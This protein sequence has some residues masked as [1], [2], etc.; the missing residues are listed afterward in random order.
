MPDRKIIAA[1]MIAMIQLNPIIFTGKAQMSQESSINP[2][3]S[4]LP[5]KSGGAV[6]S[7]ADALQALNANSEELLSVLQNCQEDA[8]SAALRNPVFDNTHL[9]VLLKR[10]N[11]GSVI[12]LIYTRKRHLNTNPVK[13]AL[14]AHPETPPHIAQAILP[15]LPVFELLKLCLMPRVSVDIHVAAERIIAQQIPAQP[16]GN[17]LTLARRGTAAILDALLRDGVQSVM[18]IC[19]D[20]PRLKEGTLHQFLAS[21]HA[22]AENVTIVA[23]N[24]RWQHRPNIRLAILKNARTPLLLFG[25]FLAGLPMGTVR[26]LLAS[27]RLTLA[28]KELVRRTVGAYRP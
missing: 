24:S 7:E 28:Q 10:R 27:P 19:L 15:L 9:L 18:E 23:R 17:K 4:A 11:I 8:L 14:V 25:E 13:C 12:Q 6:H 21:A 3:R 20:N 16:L 22:T 2:I 5:E 1:T 26:E